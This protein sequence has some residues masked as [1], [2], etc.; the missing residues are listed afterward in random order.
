[1]GTVEWLDK[2]RGIVLL[3]FVEGES[4][5]EILV[6]YEKFAQMVASAP[7]KTYTI[8]DF[9]EIHSVPSRAMGYFPQMARLTPSGD[10]RSEVIALVSQRTLVTMIT[11]IFAKV[12]PDFKDR[13]VYF[14]TVEEALDFI[15]RRIRETAA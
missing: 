12:Y 4:M 3:R 5:D 10:K 11:E 1:M 6:D 8:V 15:H 13:F 9:L 14:T 7:G 2:D